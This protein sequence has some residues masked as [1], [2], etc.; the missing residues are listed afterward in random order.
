MLIEMRDHRS[1]KI[2]GDSTRC[3]L[4]YRKAS[5]YESKSM[6]IIYHIHNNSVSKFRYLQQHKSFWVEFV[7]PNTANQFHAANVTAES[8]K[9]LS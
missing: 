5:R 8:N 2:I 9:Y 3:Q 1:S 7:A 6:V 4:A